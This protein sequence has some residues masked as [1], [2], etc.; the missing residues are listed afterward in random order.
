MAEGNG[1]VFGGPGKARITMSDKKHT[2]A[3]PAKKESLPAATSQKEGKAAGSSL[4]TM[5]EEKIRNILIG[6][7]FAQLV[8]AGLMYML[9]SIKPTILLAEAAV[10]VILALLVRFGPQESRAFRVILRVIFIVLIAVPALFAIGV[11]IWTNSLRSLDD[12]ASAQA[13]L[14]LNNW[15]M[16]ADI[17][18]PPLL[19]LQPVLALNTRN[20][21]GFDRILL[22][23][24]SGLCLVGC[25]MLCLFALEFSTPEGAEILTETTYFPVL[26]G[27]TIVIPIAFDN[28]LTRI[29]L[30]GLGAA[31]LFF[32]FLPLLRSRFGSAAPSKRKAAAADPE[33]PQE[34]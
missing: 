15:F 12:S 33:A 13:M 6:L 22:R 2:K 28:I 1:R 16:F 7:S 23:V 27:H 34:A 29:L 11:C 26:F 5:T 32:S 4:R 3:A 18:F 30:C 20:N 31:I 14:T 17:A 25:L 8:L 19:F 24:F 10:A 21:R 9:P